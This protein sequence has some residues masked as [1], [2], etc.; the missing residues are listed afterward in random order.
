[1]PDKTD[2]IWRPLRLDFEAEMRCLGQQGFNIYQYQYIK[3][4]PIPIM[5]DALLLR[6]SEGT[7]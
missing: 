2:P 5:P 7:S 4:S 6:K 3:D 1:M